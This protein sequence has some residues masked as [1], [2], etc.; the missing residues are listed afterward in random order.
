MKVILVNNLFGRHSRGGAER[1]VEMEARGLV[2]RGHEAVVISGV[3]ASD[4][5]SGGVCGIE[6]CGG[7]DVMVGGFEGG[8][9]TAEYHPK[10]L[11]FY[12]DLHLH[13]WLSRF[14]WHLFD[15][16]NSHSAII[17]MKFIRREQ[18][19][20]VHT[21]NLMGLGFDLPGFLKRENVRHVHTVHD[22]QLLHPSGLLPAGWKRPR[23]FL[24]K[25]YISVMKK[26]MGSP[27]VVIF[28]S[29][30]M[31]DLHDSLGFFPD[32]KKVLIRNPF[33]P[34][35][36]SY[37][38]AVRHR[39]L[40]IGQLENHKGT[41]DLLEAW[42][43]WGSKNGAVLHVAGAGTLEDRVSQITGVMTDAEYVGFLGDE[44]LC[45]ELDECDWLVVPSTVI[46]NAPTVI[47]GALAKGKRVIAS[48]TGG[49]PEL[50][51]DGENGILFEPGDLDGLVAA[52]KKAK[53]WSV[54]GKNNN[55]NIPTL[56][57]HLDELERCY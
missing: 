37:G 31:M 49:I 17:A 38:S 30:A 57:D 8:V 19:A 6:G 2:S 44:D 26:R 18:P 55:N 45:N 12:K 20:T 27:D 47:I 48:R 54:A 14:V 3:P 4:L 50:V 1:V 24:E 46:E 13:G 25:V 52:L 22:V 7:P 16:W 36:E 34:V 39:F 10:N 11:F 42:R 56:D 15:I 51:R 21:H 9:R 41:L 29:Q 28:P 33:M 32:S 23:G 5:A 40:F 43:V 53:S 35:S